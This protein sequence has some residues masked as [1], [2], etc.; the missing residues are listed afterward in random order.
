MMPTTTE[1]RGLQT[2]YLLVNTK[3]PVIL[4]EVYANLGLAQ[5]AGAKSAGEDLNWDYNNA[6]M[7]LAES[8]IGLLQIHGVAVHET[9]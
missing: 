7:Y 3:P 6:G 9:V 4:P 1:A 5:A 8:R 2:V